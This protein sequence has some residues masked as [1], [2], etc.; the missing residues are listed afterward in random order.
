M[1]RLKFTNRWIEFYPKYDVF[2]YDFE[3]TLDSWHVQSFRMSLLILENIQFQDWF[4]SLKHWLY[5]QIS[6]YFLQEQNFWKSHLIPQGCKRLG[7]PSFRPT[8]SCR[9]QVHP[10]MK[11]KTRFHPKNIYWTFIE[12]YHT[13]R[14]IVLVITLSIFFLKSFTK[15]MITPY[16]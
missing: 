3:I 6:K 15:I 4:P 8:S 12:N 7:I 9:Y 2:W 5:L 1:I 14:W 10:T 16:S 11:Q 13:S